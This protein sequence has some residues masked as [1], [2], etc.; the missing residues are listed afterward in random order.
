MLYRLLLVQEEMMHHTLDCVC[1][2]EK[3]V[4]LLSLHVPGLSER[5]P[6]LGQGDIV[7]AKHG[8]KKMAYQVFSLESIMEVLL[9][10]AENFE[11]FSR[12]T[13]I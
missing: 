13:L 4:D 5:R 6:S 3:G 9:F 10:C 12:R 1:L 8:S 2:K 11:V 7:F